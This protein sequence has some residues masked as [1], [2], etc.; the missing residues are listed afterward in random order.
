MT[1]LRN[2][3]MEVLEFYGYEIKEQHEKYISAEKE[4]IRVAVGIL[5]EGDFKEVLAFVNAVEGVPALHIIVTLKPLTGDAFDMAE[6]NGLI[7]WPREEIEREVGTAVLGRY[8]RGER[9]KA[10][11]E[12][13]IEKPQVTVASLDAELSEERD[14]G[15]KSAGGPSESAT[16]EMVLKPV[17]TLEDITELSR[18]T[19]R[20][21]RF[22]LEL[23]PHYIYEFECE[24]E[25]EGNGEHEDERRTGLISVNALTG[26]CKKWEDNLET[27]S[28]IEPG[29]TRMEPKLEETEVYEKALRCAV[30]LNTSEVSVM[31]DREHATIIENRR[32][33]P[34]DG[35][36][37]LTRKGMIY[38]P[39]WCVEG[40]NGVMIVDAATGKIIKED[41]YCRKS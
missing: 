17:M 23:V 9:G 15:G 36:V 21:F 19:V 8:H 22:D 34:K 35:K 2:V 33:S 32:I 24:L 4:G 16:A 5:A 38:E 1:S 27:V 41:Y 39:I 10:F 14:R 18:K 13:F 28:D 40:T 12:R 30:K 3:L 26:A 37:S 20:G 29:H 6:E 31:K 25:V 11:F 7:I